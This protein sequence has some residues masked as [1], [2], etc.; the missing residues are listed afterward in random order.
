MWSSPPGSDP[1]VAGRRPAQRVIATFPGPS[2]RDRTCKGTVAVAAS[3]PGSGSGF[4]DA[5]PVGSA[6]PIIE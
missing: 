1:P 6:A 5:G 4:S 2:T 3:Y